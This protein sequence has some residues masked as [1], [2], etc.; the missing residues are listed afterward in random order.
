MQSIFKV[1][2][3]KCFVT[4]LF[5]S[6]EAHCFCHCHFCRIIFLP[7]FWAVLSSVVVFPLMHTWL[8]LTQ[9]SQDVLRH[10]MFSAILGLFKMHGEFFIHFSSTFRRTWFSIVN[11]IW[12]LWPKEH[13]GAFLGAQVYPEKAV[14]FFSLSAVDRTGIS[15][16][17]KAWVTGGNKVCVTLTITVT[18]KALFPPKGTPFAVMRSPLHS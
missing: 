9:F 15:G 13:V 4:L 1:G 3:R 6:H 10:G 8:L 18:S 7:C 5:L 12:T 14:F 17:H 11:G 2:C 16:E